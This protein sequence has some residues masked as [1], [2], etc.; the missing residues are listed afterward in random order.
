LKPKR[1]PQKTDGNVTR[2]LIYQKHK[3]LSYINGRWV[4]NTVLFEEKPSRKK[5]ENHFYQN[6]LKEYN[7]KLT[8]TLFKID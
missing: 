8:S 3:L 5:I 6:F 2:K 7:E 1:I 4:N